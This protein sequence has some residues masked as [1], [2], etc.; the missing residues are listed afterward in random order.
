MLDASAVSALVVWRFVFL[1]CCRNV[2]DVTFAAANKFESGSLKSSNDVTTM[3]RSLWAA[4]TCDEE[5]RI[6]SGFARNAATEE[7]DCSLFWNRITLAF[8]SPYYAITIFLK[9][10]NWAFL[11]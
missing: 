1:V 7:C 5:K 3:V 6:R 2:S 9:D 10:W 4:V 11:H 8:Y